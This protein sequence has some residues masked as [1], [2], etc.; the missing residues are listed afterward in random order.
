MEQHLLSWFEASG[1]WAFFTSLLF[2]TVFSIFAFIPSVFLTAANMA[3][4]GFSKGLLI[5]FLGEISGAMTSF[6]LYRWGINSL[7]ERELFKNKYIKKL[8][9]T[10]RGEAF[11][12]IVMLRTFPFVPSGAVN[13]A[14]AFSKTGFFTFALASSVGKIPSI[15]IEGYSVKQVMDWSWEGKLI[16]GFFSFCILIFYLK[17]KK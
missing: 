13:I 14:A 7:G 16:L 17:R 8:S 9:N 5:S 4:F 10:S 1:P 15:L 6:L 12:L 2:N 11:I 3:F